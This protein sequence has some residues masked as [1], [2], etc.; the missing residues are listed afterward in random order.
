MDCADDPVTVASRLAGVD[1][2]VA[3][4]YRVRAR[5]G[6]G[7]MKE[8]YLAYDERLDR[9]VALA[10]VVGAAASDGARARVA[11]EAQVTGRLGDHP[12]VITVYDSGELDG[13]PY[14]VLRAM[15]GGSLAEAMRRGRPSTQDTIRV[16]VE[17]AAGLAHA[18]GHGV[19][20]RDVKPDN[21][22]LTGDGSAAL[23]DFGIASQAGQERLTAD[24]VVVGT[25]R[26]LSPEQIRGDGVCDASDLY[27][28]GV[29]L[30][31]LTT[32]RTPFD[33]SDPTEVLTQH[34]TA[35]PLAP[36]EIAADVPPRLERLILELLSKRP[37]Q[38]P[39]SAL[40][41]QRELASMAAGESHG[42]T[43]RTS[44]SSAS[45]LPVPATELLARD[46]DLEA[47]AALIGADRT[48][49][50][51]LIGPGG[52]GK[53]RLAIESA[54][55]LADDFADGA[56]FVSLVSVAEARELPAVVA[57]AL[58]APT[59]DGEAPIVALQRLLA[60][61][62][63]LLVLDNFEHLVAGA[64]F[65]G[66]LLGASPG[67]T[68]L[69]TSRE[70]TRLAAERLY[71]VRPLA[72]PD[73]SAQSIGGYGA[74]ALFVERARAREPD[75]ELDAANAPAVR[76]ICRRLD[77]L[78]L[79][80]ELAAARVGLLSPAELAARLDQALAVLGTGARDA[81]ARH[82]TLRAAIDW[83]FG[84]L[85]TSERDGFAAL[86]AF[87]GGATVAAAECVTGASLDT[88]D[89]LVAKQLLV[90]RG[91]RLAMLE[92]VR[93]Y[94]VER[95]AEHPGR[96]GVRERLAEWCLTFAR[97]AT[98]HIG[99]ADQ[100]AWVA[101]LD[102]ERP[103]LLAALSWALEGGHEEL[104]LE[105]AVALGPYWL[106][107]GQAGEGF[108]WIDAAVQRSREAPVRTHANALLWRARVAG[109]RSGAGH[110][111]DLQAALELFRS[112]ADD[113]GI[114][115]CLSAIVDSEAWHGRPENTSPLIDEAMRCA[116]RAGDEE[117]TAAVLKARARAAVDYDD[118]LPL[119]GTALEYL[120]R[121][122]MIGDAGDLC[123]TTGYVALSER[124]Y[125]EAIAWLTDGLEIANTDLGAEHVFYPRSN[126]GLARLFLDELDEAAA[127]FS[128]ALAVCREAAGE[129]ALFETLLG[130]GG[131]AARRGR[132]QHAA[133][134]AGAAA[135][136][137]S[138]ALTQAEAEVAAR[139][140]DEIL[141]RGRVSY[142][143]DRW[144]RAAA[145]GASLTVSEAIDLGLE[146]GAFAAR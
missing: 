142:G 98:P 56:R 92:T 53:T 34:L 32:G 69:V 31:E 68:V 77:G 52:V 61:R 16:G 30:Y 144:D 13:V 86:A 10:I 99:R 81:P 44:P 118:M 95:L 137:A 84:L 128:T 5:L 89:S 110:G 50:V 11:R 125:R 91:G 131:V 74:V 19:V 46:A 108:R 1:A 39:A 40:D 71:P 27:A 62:T 15:H 126:E 18:H 141:S 130:L 33:A 115:H 38:R 9:E 43:A 87:P 133:R 29:T 90:R 111:D 60:D 136:H 146:R 8:V 134:L 20:H 114:A 51:T 36:S 135:R 93:E 124:R 116:R 2:L 106:R 28:L 66:E 47:L 127:S 119:A 85:S 76:E 42:L 24:G 73:A 132:Y 88:L 80:I 103:N 145:E 23:G 140:K 59:R 35:Q 6:R 97:E 139:L 107:T 70:P 7:A 14:L 82:R 102:A 122:G 104:A 112:C 78:P 25:V 22:W 65:V 75:F 72:V 94:A 49:V 105:L 117:A 123:N 143:P 3:G 21:V 12:N 54:R 79:A 113:A 37:E 64:A 67:L 83:S 138:A 4:R 48:R 109:V 45:A 121:A 26:Y 58:A 120:R 96:D 100:V 57:R 101:R 41:V 129:E 55:R 63:L 17:I